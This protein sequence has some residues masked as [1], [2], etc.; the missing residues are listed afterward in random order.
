MSGKRSKQV[1]K[2]AKYMEVKCNGEKPAKF[3]AKKLKAHLNGKLD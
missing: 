1:R 2:V 3:W